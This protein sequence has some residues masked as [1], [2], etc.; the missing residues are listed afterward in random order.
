MGNPGSYETSE[1][2]VLWEDFHTNTLH[3]MIDTLSADYPNNIFYCIPYGRA[4][5]ELKGL[6]E[7]GDLSDVNNFI[8]DFET[9]LFIDLKG[10]PGKILV[11]FGVLIWL[12]AIYGVDLNSYEYNSDFTTDLRTMASEIMAAH[13]P[14]YNAF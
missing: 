10:H 8:G 6:Y 3:V 7:S 4:A 12:E 5:I 11:E 9:S 1:M 14:V 13:D 2:E